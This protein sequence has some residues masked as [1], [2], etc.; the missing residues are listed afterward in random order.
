MRSMR[1]YYLLR[2][3]EEM[4]ALQLVLT[5]CADLLSEK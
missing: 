5:D 2:S 3:I 1:A 4:M